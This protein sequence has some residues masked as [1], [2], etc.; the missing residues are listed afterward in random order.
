MSEK[1]ALS[2]RIDTLE[3]RFTFLD[4]TIETL[5]QTITAQWQ[6]IDALTRQLA[7]LERTAAGSRGTRPRRQRTSAALLRVSAS[8]SRMSP[9]PLATVTA[10]H[11]IGE[12]CFERPLRGA[13]SAA[14]SNSGLAVIETALTLSQSDRRIASRISRRASIRGRLR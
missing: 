5:N 14:W 4:E 6:Q 3:S 10:H 8:R 12:T 7:I 9:P 2:D 1:Q 11:T 13:S